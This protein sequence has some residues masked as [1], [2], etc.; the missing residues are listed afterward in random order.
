MD[1]FDVWFEERKDRFLEEMK[2]S[3]TIKRYMKAAYHLGLDDGQEYTYRDIKAVMAAIKRSIEIPVN[4]ERMEELWNAYMNDPDHN[5]NINIGIAKG[6]LNVVMS[7]TGGKSTCW[8]SN[9]EAPL[10]REQQIALMTSAKERHEEHIKRIRD[11]LMEN[12]DVND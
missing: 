4:E 6:P 10:N 12:E 1:N 11:I 3:D 7:G 2:D 9:Q 8:A 5:G